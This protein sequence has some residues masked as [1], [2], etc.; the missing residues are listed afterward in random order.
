[1]I[2]IF[3]IKR[4][5]VYLAFFP[6]R[7]LSFEH[8][9]LGRISDDSTTQ[10]K[11]ISL[12]KIVGIRKLCVHLKTISSWRF[13]ETNKKIDIFDQIVHRYRKFQLFLSSRRQTKHIYFEGD[14]VSTIPFLVDRTQSDKR[15]S[16]IH[17]HRYTRFQPLIKEQKIYLNY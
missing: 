16:A 7:T 15:L 12:N 17:S 9:F 4:T 5:T 11:M 1:M 13:D 10:S 6:F 8:K 2:I 14:V 3:T